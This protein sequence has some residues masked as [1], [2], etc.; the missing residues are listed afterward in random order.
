MKYFPFLFLLVIGL[1]L[2]GCSAPVSSSTIQPSVELLATTP[3]LSPAT[4]TQAATDQPVQPSGA[5]AIQ[6]A[7]LTDSQGA[8][9]V[10]VKSLDLNSS[11]D[12][13]D[14]EVALDTHSI[15]LSM[16]LAALAT[17]TTDTGLSVQAAKWDAL[18]G[19]HHVSGTLS[20]PSTLE[21]KAILD[22]ASTLT[23]II[24]DVDASERVF[25]WDLE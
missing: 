7:E 3:S 1:I 20:F 23:L 15:D 8:V 18:L 13:L 4:P 9:T 2:A 17:L 10:I 5:Q 19:G 24:K 12:K 6:L 25:A 16:D 22:G 14:F 11:Q 21:G